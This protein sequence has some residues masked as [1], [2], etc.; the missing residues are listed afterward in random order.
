VVAEEELVL[1]LLDVADAR[2]DDF[3]LKKVGRLF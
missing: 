2:V 1:Q 3:E